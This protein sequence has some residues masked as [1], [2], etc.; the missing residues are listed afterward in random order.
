MTNRYEKGELPP[1]GEKA[2]L[3]CDCEFL[4]LQ[5]GKVTKVRSGTLV[6]V[7]GHSKRPD[8]GYFNVVLMCV[9]N[10]DVGSCVGNHEVILSPIKS[11]Q[12]Q[13]REAFIK[14]VQE[15]MG[16]K[17]DWNIQ[18]VSETAH[19]MYKAGYRKVKPLNFERFANAVSA[20]YAGYAFK[21][22]LENNHIV[23]EGE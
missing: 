17:E 16:C 21:W 23:S 14:D 3:D 5:T 22:L 2:R 20:G 13:E 4:C 10:L 19:S 1:V 6:E 7:T 9:D 8:N 11:K 15:L 12:E 18:A